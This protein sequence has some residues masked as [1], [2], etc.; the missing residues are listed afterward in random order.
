MNPKFSAYTQV[1][2]D[3][4]FNVT[5]LAPPSTNVL[6]HE[7]RGERGTWDPHGSN[8]WYIGPSMGHYRCYRIW[9]VDSRAERVADTL[10]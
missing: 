6:V 5:P 4:D 10:V 1:K 8:A 3:F 7:K 9:M 2:G